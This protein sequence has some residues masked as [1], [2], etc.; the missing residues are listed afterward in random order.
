MN[1]FFYERT[2]FYIWDSVSTAAA[3]LDSFWERSR[4]ILK[5]FLENIF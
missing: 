3:C 2:F 4:L 1:G 5:I